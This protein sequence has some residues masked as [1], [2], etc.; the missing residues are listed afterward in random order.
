MKIVIPRIKRF[1]SLIIADILHKKNLPSRSTQNKY[2]NCIFLFFIFIM[3]NITIYQF[4]VT[5]FIIHILYVSTTKMKVLPS[6]IKTI[7]FF[8]KYNMNSFHPFIYIILAL[9]KL[10][11]NPE[12]LMHTPKLYNGGFLDTYKKHKNLWL[13]KNQK[14]NNLKKLNKFNQKNQ[15]LYSEYL[16]LSNTVAL[17]QI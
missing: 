9:Y 15:Y 12:D 17:S 13:N 7:I 14:N 5:T 1:H 3:Y 6:S 8:K 4:V 11:V 10:L 16:Y 2:N